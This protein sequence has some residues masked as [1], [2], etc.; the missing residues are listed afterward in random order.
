MSVQWRN[1]PGLACTR[2]GKH[3]RKD[4]YHTVKT[5]HTWWR[6]QGHVSQT[7]SVS[8]SMKLQISG[9]QETK[10]CMYQGPVKP[11]EMHTHHHISATIYVRIEPKYGPRGMER[12][13][14]TVPIKR[15]WKKGPHMRPRV[16]VNGEWPRPVRGLDALICGWRE[17]IIQQHQHQT[18]NTNINT[19]TGPACVHPGTTPVYV[20]KD[21]PVVSQ[22]GRGV[23]SSGMKDSGTYGFYFRARSSNSKP[24]LDVDRDASFPERRS[25]SLSPSERY[26]FIT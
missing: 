20:Q 9:R 8:P 11:T 3:S 1:M 24:G 17:N 14:E 12:H 6:R 4:R 5:S 16:R 23:G 18:P 22:R 25:L 2:M 13:I 10:T 7:H 15:G 21:A 19:N 26:S